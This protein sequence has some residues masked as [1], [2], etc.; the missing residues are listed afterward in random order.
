[1][2]GALRKGAALKLGVAQ[3]AIIEMALRQYAETQNLSVE[4][5]RDLIKRDKDLQ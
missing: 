5:A 1:M 4:E 2:G 3:A